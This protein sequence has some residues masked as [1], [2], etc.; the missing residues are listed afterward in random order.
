MF[1]WSINYVDIGFVNDDRTI[2]V[3]DYMLN[4]TTKKVEVSGGKARQQTVSKGT[5]SVYS[6]DITLRTIGTL[7]SGIPVWAKI[8]ASRNTYKFTMLVIDAA[9]LYDQ[10]GVPH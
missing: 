6:K 8:R 4:V 10:Y 3:P 1:A 7:Q 5:F 9:A 2:I